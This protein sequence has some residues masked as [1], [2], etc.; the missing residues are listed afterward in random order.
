MLYGPRAQG[1]AS[2]RGKSRAAQGHPREGTRELA[3]SSPKPHPAHDPRSALPRGGGRGYL[4]GEKNIP[5]ERRIFVNRNLR[6]A[7]VKALGFDMDHT[8]AMYRRETF[9]QLTHQ[10]AVENLVQWKGYPEVVRETRYNPAFIIRG[11]IVDKRYGNILKMDAHNYIARVFHGSKPLARSKRKRLYRGSTINLRSDRYQ[12]FDTLFSLP[13]GSL[14][15]SLIDMK[16]ERRDPFFKEMS[17]TR[18]FDD[19]RACVDK[20]HRDGTLKALLAKDLGRYLLLYPELAATLQRFRS[21]GKKVFLITNSEHDYTDRVLS[22]VLGPAVANWRELFD[23]VIV[24]S[25]KPGFFTESRAV[26][27]I[28]GGEAGGRSGFVFRGG[29]A[30]FVEEFLGAN[31]DQ[32]LYIGDHTYGDILRSKKT[33][34]WRTGMIVEEL[35]SEIAANRRLQYQSRELGDLVNRCID[36]AR[37]RDQLALLLT[38]MRERLSNPAGN[39]NGAPPGAGEYIGRE[40][41]QFDSLP[42]AQRD[43]RADQTREVLQ[44]LDFLTDQYT[45][46]I[47]ELQLEISLE[48]NPYWGPLFREGNNTSRFGRQVKEFACIYTSRVSNFL[49]YS[50]NTYFISP[51]ERMPHET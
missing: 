45:A 11:L 1:A 7:G 14:Y 24:E 3:V 9:E 44:G 48:H 5:R 10:L 31:G 35:E 19:V 13:E 22:F 8:L 41:E 6:M 20:C 49:N 28:A 12:S 23:L 27:P 34:G 29:D 2:S 32:V 50:A 17:P 18:L 25:G 39:G 38:S 42:M 4:P 47:D 16:D 46:R 21:A 36:L 51:E 30:S 26:T 15:A 43:A 37:D 33:F 40:L